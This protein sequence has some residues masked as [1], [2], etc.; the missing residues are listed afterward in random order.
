MKNPANK[1][2]LF[3]KILPVMKRQ[4]PYFSLAAVRRALKEGGAT[5]ADE[6]L[7][8]YMSEAMVSGIVSDAGRG[9]Y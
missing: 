8:E 3:K 1:T 4:T 2:L 9:W 6:T 7:R 5:L